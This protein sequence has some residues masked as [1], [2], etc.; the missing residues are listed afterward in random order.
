MDIYKSLAHH[1]V[2]QSQVVMRNYTPTGWWENDVF[3][4]TKDGRWIEYE[5]KTSRSDFLKDKYKARTFRGVSISKHDCLASDEEKGP[6]RFY[7]VVPHDL[8]IDVPSWAGLMVAKLGRYG[9]SFGVEKQ[10]PLRHARPVD[11]DVTHAIF[12]TAYWRMVGHWNGSSDEFSE[13]LGI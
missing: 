12:R 10:A 11:K 6:N 3:R 1:L 4:V 7:F 8:V 9:I 5:I 13:G 2:R